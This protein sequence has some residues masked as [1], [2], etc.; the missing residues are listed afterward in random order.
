MI[1]PVNC[2]GKDFPEINAGD[3]NLFDGSMVFFGTVQ[4]TRRKDR[5]VIDRSA[6]NCTSA[7]TYGFNGTTGALLWELDRIIVDK[8]DGPGQK[9]DSGSG[10]KGISI[11][12]IDGDGAEEV[13]CGFG[14]VVFFGQ[15]GRRID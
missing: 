9:I 3:I 5:D 1:T 2:Y 10:G 7:K 14:N 11:F 15:R 13:M 6:W 8:G 12:D 4:S